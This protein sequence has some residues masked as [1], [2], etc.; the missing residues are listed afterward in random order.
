MNDVVI[1]SV[2]LAGMRRALQMYL[3]LFFAKLETVNYFKKKKI[4]LKRKQNTDC[5]FIGT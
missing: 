4:L 5:K 1:L 2:S 3:L